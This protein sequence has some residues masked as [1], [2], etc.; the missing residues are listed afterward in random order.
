MSSSPPAGHRERLSPSLSWWAAVAG[1]ALT[2]GWLVLVLAP[3]LVAAGVTVVVGAVLGAGLAAWGSL[4]I[5]VDEHLRAG[6]ARIEPQ[7]LGAVTTLD[8]AAYRH[9]MGPGAHGRALLVTRP[10]IDRGVRVDITDP[11][12]PTPYW[13][14]GSRHPD[15]LAAAVERIR[16]TG[17]TPDPAAGRTDDDGG[18]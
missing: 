13:L 17:T 3:L 6:P 10:W 9:L 2:C 5:G 18:A 16:Q 11:R 7:H 15:A 1:F 12:D 14:L 8:R 4:Q